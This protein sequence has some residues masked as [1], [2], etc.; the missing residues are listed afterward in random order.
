ME[1]PTLKMINNIGEMPL[2]ERIV[3]GPKTG[4]GAVLPTHN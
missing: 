4:F 2:V 1:K 3:S